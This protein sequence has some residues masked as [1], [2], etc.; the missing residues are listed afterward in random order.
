MRR[1]TIRPARIKGYSAEQKEAAFR[2]PYAPR[3][4]IKAARQGL[5]IR[6]SNIRPAHKESYSAEQR[7]AAF[8]PPYAPRDAKTGQSAYFQIFEKQAKLKIF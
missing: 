3:N 6:R 1:S 4:A 7:E 5:S 8:R 2:P